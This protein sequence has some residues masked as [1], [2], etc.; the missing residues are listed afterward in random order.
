M[1]AYSIHVVRIAQSP[2][3][4][5]GVLLK[6]QQSVVGVADCPGRGGGAGGVGI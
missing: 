1:S 5:E 2:Y 6:R 3:W 4:V